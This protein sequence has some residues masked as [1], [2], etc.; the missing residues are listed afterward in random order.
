MKTAIS[1]SGRRIVF[2]S[3]SAADPEELWTTNLEFKA[4][5]RVTNTQAIFDRYVMGETRIIEWKTLDGE[6]AYGAVLLPAGYQPG[7]RY[8]LIV[9]QYPIGSLVKMGQLLWI[10]SFSQ[11]RRKLAV[12]CNA[13]ICSAFT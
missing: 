4:P 7:K 1:E 2:A 10:E 5:Q 9:Y 8:P 3:Q 12:V 11:L 6:R 13:G